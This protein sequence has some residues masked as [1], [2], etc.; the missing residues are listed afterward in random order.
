M[1]RISNMLTFDIEEWFHANYDHI[2]PADYR[3]KGSRFRAHMDGLLQM[4]SDTGSKATFFVLGCIGEDYPEVVKEIARQGHDVA[5]HGYGHEL[6]YSQT[7]DAFKADVK[8][9]VDILEDLTGTKVLGYRAPSWSIVER[10]LH[11]LEALEELGLQY[12]ASIFPV[13]TFLYG[14]PDAPTEIHKPKVGGRELRLYEVPMS[15]MN[16]AGRNMGYSGG[17][18]FRFFPRLFIKQ[19]IKA[20]NRRGSSAIVYLHPRE[21]DAGEQK[22]SLPPKEHF[23]HYYNVRGTKSKLESVLKSFRFTSVSEHLKQHCG[24]EV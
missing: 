1:E 22:L 17:F 21:I 3:G 9:S 10:N 2:N 8:K 19:A 5:S 11:Y 24:L 23:I 7:Y 15:V 6:A 16:L 20:A 12:D 18:Y 4:C 13:Q 14:I